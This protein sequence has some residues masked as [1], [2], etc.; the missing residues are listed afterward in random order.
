MKQLILFLFL[1]ICGLWSIDGWG[2]NLNIVSIDPQAGSNNTALSANITV[3]FDLNI[4]AASLSSTNVIVRGSQTGVISGV[5]SGGGSTTVTFNPINNYKSG[6]V[7]S[8]TITKAL[9][10]QTGFN[11]LRGHT[12]SF[13]AITGPA[14]SSPPTFA[15]RRVNFTSASAPD[16]DISALDFDGDGDLD[17]IVS[18][19][20]PI[21]EQTELWINDGNQGF[22]KRTI[23]EF[24]NIEVYDIDGDGDFDSFGPGGNGVNL[25]WYRNE[26]D[27]GA[28]TQ[29]LIGGTTIMW[30][31]TGGDL[32]SDGDI[33]A[34]AMMSNGNG[35]QSLRWFTNNGAGVFS[36]T[37]IPTAFTVGSESQTYLYIVDINK[38]GAM[39]ILAYR[40]NGDN[41]VWYEN[42][43]SQVFTERII[44]N[45]PENLRLFTA[46]V[47]GDGDT[48]ILSAGNS[49]A[50]SLSWY[51]NDGS[52]NFTKHS[53]PVSSPNRLYTVKAV[54]IDGD[55][56]MDLL[57]GGYWF[58]NDGSENF[59]Q[60]S[61]TPGLVFNSGGS[62]IS[63]ATN[64][65]DMDGDGDMDILSLGFL[66]NGF[67]WQENVQFMNVT[68][69]APANAAFSV[70][71]NSNITVTFDQ[72]IDNTSITGNS[73]RVISKLRGIVSGT[74]SGGGTNTVVFN[75]SKD[76]LPGEEIEVAITE[77][78]KSTSGH[79]LETTYGFDFKARTPISGS[80][81]FTSSSI[82][83]H[84]T[85]ALWMDVAD[86]DD[87]GD[88]D[89]V[90]CSSTELFW[91]RNDGNGNFTSIPVTTTGSPRR[92]FATDYN[93]DGNMDVIIQTSGAPLLYLNDGNENFSESQPK[94]LSGTIYELVDVSRDGDTDAMA[95]TRWLDR[96]C[97]NY[98]IGMLPTLTGTASSI[99]AGDLDNDGDIDFFRSLTSV[100]SSFL[101][102]DG[103][104]NYSNT[105]IASAGLSYTDLVD[106]DGDGDLDA[107]GVQPNSSIVWYE[108]NLLTASQNFGAKKTIGVLAA[109]PRWV[110]ASDLDGDGDPDVAA[111]SRTDDKVVW[112]ENRLNEASANFAAAQLL[113]TISD[114][115]IQI[116]SADLNGDGKMD[117]IVLSDIDNE[118]V[119]YTNAS[120]TA[121]PTI[122]SFS[123][124]SGPVGTTVIITGT[125]FSTTPSNNTVLFKV[126]YDGTDGSPTNVVAV[127]TASTT[128]SI[129]TSVPATAVT[130]KISVTT[131]GG[132]AQSASNF[133]VTCG[134]LPTITSFTPVTGA[135]GTTVVITGTNFSTTPNDNI[136]DFGGYSAAVISSTT[137]TVTTSV[138]TG[139]I[140][141]VPINITIACNTITSPTDFDVTCLP[142]PTIT[143]FTPSTGAVGDVVTITG[144]NFSTNPL[145]NFVDFNGEPAIVTASTSTSITTSVPANTFTGPINV[146]VGCDAASSST[147]FIVDC[148]P[149]PTIT[150]FS[151]IIGLDGN[152][153]TITGTNFSTTPV[154]NLVDFNGQPA[155]VTASTTTSITTTVPMG[156]INGPISILIDCNYVTSTIDFIVGTDITITTQ[157]SNF[158][159][160]VGDIATFTATATGTNNITYQWEQQQADLT[161]SDIVD[162]G[163]YSGST[164][165][166]L[167]VN[168]G[169]G[170]VSPGYR[171]RINGDLAN[172][173][174]SNTANLLL[175][176]SPTPPL[177][178]GANSCAPAALTLSA[179]DG[180]DG[181]YR[182]YTSA[183]G[184]APIS[185]EVNDTFTTP[186]LS[187][188]IT[189]YV[190]LATACESARTA[191]TATIGGAACT[192]QPPVIATTTVSTSIQGK[193][194]IDLKSLISDVDGN[195]DFASFKIIS[196]PVSGAA[197]EITNA[198]LTINYSG[199]SFSGQ[200]KITIE[201][202]DL[203]GSC[204]QQELI[205]NVADEIF[206]FNGISPNGDLFN[207]KWIIQNIESL[208]D[209]REN[210]VSIFNRWGD[211]IF[212]A[213]N[214]DNDTR[215]FKGVNK[216]GSEVTS[217]VYFYKIEFPSGR[218]SMSGYLTVKK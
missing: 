96:N 12:Y 112:Y 86:M 140:G 97:D 80:P 14:A 169:I 117:L 38:D 6:E 2:Q 30:T 194:T 115:P 198:L 213:S 72:L 137:T 109:D 101:L 25:N 33:D 171:C 91:H 176:L 102:N 212:E 65:A 85:A 16:N 110:V 166:A 147:D 164:T 132:Y 138:P 17:L 99:T 103:Y 54:D 113:P 79:R 52:E 44:I 71:A 148:G 127:V 67:R 50:V 1:S 62:V 88:V 193:V 129:T 23:G 13:T 160:C 175:Q 192:N 203:L 29:V 98:S 58:D 37:F 22:C 108:N 87:D 210:K 100:S 158:S 55:S 167:V 173:V 159:G 7:I 32:D 76:F 26:G 146:Y 9:L 21:S 56:D 136:I 68:S 84:A 141:L 69:T 49:S 28:F 75:P 45:D 202:C 74:F 191:V 130:G 162:G 60:K 34:V 156:A 116:K 36:Q 111:V 57:A 207:E 134:P 20:V 152:I 128:T 95:G 94:G 43:G 82:K 214:Y 42:N 59:T 78:I 121:A 211:Q 126:Y 208:S 205:I 46:D 66:G 15:Q 142:S 19:D 61:T 27:G 209:T 186:S 77:K 118:L 155:V 135:V 24:R 131:S 190:S 157:P 170:T 151:P 174:I 161:F 105:V 64:Y 189:Y 125:N 143:S 123:P 188:T 181:Q 144:T 35:T 163:A 197:A 133:I 63:F 41:I 124:A 200:D 201:V 10:S 90:S 93:N 40:D 70:T 182:W 73:F 104:L 206:V 149:V 180:I 81:T 18:T 218:K 196:T 184:G 3:T 178:V 172:E 4:D 217:G 48:D 199:L 114:G 177:T 51:E 31:V 204:S 153:V 185:G 179:S 183:S 187:T 11:L 122:T 216:N 83:F 47:D 53:V 139:P 145:D 92:V 106:L 195:I 165:S 150:S 215:V 107:L 89:I 168:T 5:L 39:D 119:W 8:V 154:N 120:T